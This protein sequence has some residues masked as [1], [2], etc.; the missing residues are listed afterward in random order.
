MLHGIN[1]LI[2]AI[3]GIKAP[4]SGLRADLVTNS[5]NFTSLIY[6]GVNITLLFP[7]FWKLISSSALVSSNNYLN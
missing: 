5:A 3:H 7:V 6:S 4:E 1:E 2:L